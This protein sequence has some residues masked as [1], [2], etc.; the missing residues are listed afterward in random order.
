[1]GQK[2]IVGNKKV[3]FALLNPISGG[4]CILHFVNFLG[5]HAL[6][7]PK[8]VL[9]THEDLIVVWKSQGI[10]FLLESEQ[11]EYFTDSDIQPNC[12]LFASISKYGR[13][14]NQFC[15]GLVGGGG[16]G[17]KL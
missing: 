5:E 4:K 1:M 17:G 8:T 10:S 3:I 16:G 2:N 12:A 9:D 7:P 13:K 6:R 15:T 14:A 11:P